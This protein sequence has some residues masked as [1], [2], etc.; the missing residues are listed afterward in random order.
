[1]NARFMTAKIWHSILI[2]ATLLLANSDALIA[3]EFW[4]PSMK[5]FASGFQHLE[6][7]WKA[8]DLSKVAE[9]AAKISRQSRL[10][11][12]S[13]NSIPAEKRSSFASHLN[14]LHRLNNQLAESATAGDARFAEWY[15]NEIR[16]T[17]V[18]CHAGFRDLNNLAGFYPAKGNTVIA[19][20]SVYSADGQPKGDNSGSVVFIDGL[21]RAAQK[22]QPHPI[23]SQQNR[24]FSPRVLPIVRDTTVDFPNDDSI[25]HNVFSLS[26]TRRFD[27]DIYQPGRSKSVKFSKPGLVRLYC[28][29][30]P[31]MNCSILVLNNP[32]FSTTDRTGRWIISGIPDGTFSVRTWQELGGEA[33]QRVTLSGSSVVQLPLKVQEAL[34]TETSTDC[35]TRS[36]ANTNEVSQCSSQIVR[37]DGH[38]HRRLRADVSADRHARC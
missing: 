36:R 9:H 35:R 31:E 8:N 7:D 12:Q 38:G 17:C 3:E 5:E 25:L 13:Q 29:I 30:H 11:G 37:R 16:R 26:K 34:P 23:V 24:Q 18:S 21:V 22:G 4:L 6:Q 27:L 2:A 33:R 19:D 20:V 14:T 10:L 28:N 32:Y 1:M 15:V